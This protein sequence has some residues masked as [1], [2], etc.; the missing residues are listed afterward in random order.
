MLKQHVDADDDIIDIDI[1][2]DDDNDDDS[3]RGVHFANHHVSP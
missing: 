3:Y 2:D 1:D